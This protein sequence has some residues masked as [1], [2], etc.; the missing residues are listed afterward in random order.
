MEV[1]SDNLSSFLEL[2]VTPKER[3]RR[4]QFN[5]LVCA[6]QIP[7][8]CYSCKGELD[9]GLHEFKNIESNGVK[10]GKLILVSMMVAFVV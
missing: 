9:T 8:T 6:S 1:S 3:M 10:K 2:V 4:K 7:W 5:A